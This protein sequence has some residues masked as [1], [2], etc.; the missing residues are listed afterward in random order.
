MKSFSLFPLPARSSLLAGVLS[1]LLANSA[2]AQLGQSS[3]DFEIKH[4]QEKGKVQ[5]TYQN[6]TWNANAGETI[7]LRAP[8]GD[9]VNLIVTNPNTL[10]LSYKLGEQ[11]ETDTADYAALKAFATAL[12]GFF[13]AVDA[14]A[15]EAKVASGEAAD[16]NQDEKEGALISTLP[17]ETAM[18]KLEGVTLTDSALEGIGELVSTFGNIPTWVEQST[19]SESL[20]YD[21]RETQN[22]LK[23]IVQI[24]AFL[25]QLENQLLLGPSSDS[26]EAFDGNGGA[27]GFYSANGIMT[28]TTG[29]GAVLG[30]VYQAR[31]RLQELR[32]YVAKFHT[33][34]IAY[35]TAVAANRLAIGEVVVKATKDIS[36]PVEISANSTYVVATN[37]AA[38][39]DFQDKQLG[40]YTLLISPR[41][42]FHLRP[43]VGVIYSFVKNPEYG[44][45]SNEDGSI[46]VT[47]NT[48]DY[49][50]FSGVISLNIYP[51]R[52][53]NEPV[54]PFLQ[55]GA[56]PT[57]E[58]KALLLGLGF[59]AYKKFNLSVGGI[60]QERRTLGGGQS[61]G[62][63]LSAAEDLEVNHE[64]KSG[65]FVQ[66]GVDF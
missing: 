64:F 42:S 34:F 14:T 41:Q 26:I 29:F 55:L 66:V 15:E 17:P 30:G 63:I 60:Y 10:L 12:K 40:N 58:S 45:A 25:D 6:K 3:S 46:R 59:S 49:N 50:E 8:R 52:W 65:I 9:K 28:D 38:T 23:K 44:V 19:D 33:D 32:D 35:Q 13:G 20:D 27:L 37:R 2:T 47:E 61:V 18:L 54:K 51:D 62:D 48:A 11:T 39:T 36:Q 24:S 21:I 57:T 22:M 53:F 16:H 1:A 31:N 5:V 7:S 4:L 43:G 56:S